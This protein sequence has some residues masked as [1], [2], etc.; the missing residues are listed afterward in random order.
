MAPHATLY[1][2]EAQSNSL[3]DLFCTVTVAGN[4]VNAAGGGEVSMSWGSGEFSAETLGGP[5]LHK[6]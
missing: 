5:S 3:L 2:V 1:L 6:A 4:L